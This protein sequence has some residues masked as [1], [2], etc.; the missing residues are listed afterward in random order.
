MDLTLLTLIKSLISMFLLMSLGFLLAKLKSEFSAFSGPMAELLMTIFLPATIIQSLLGER[1]ESFLRDATIVFFIG[2]ILYVVL[3][4]LSLFFA[5]VCKIRPY[6]RGTWALCATFPNNGFMGYPII[7]AM[8]GQEALALAAV[9]GVSFS[10]IFYTWG[11]HIISTDKKDSQTEKVSLK[12]A[13]IT[14]TN[15]ATLVGILCFVFG[16]QIPEV[17]LT[18]ISLCANVST[19]LSM[20][21]IGIKLAE[22]KKLKSAINMDVITASL[23]KLIIFPAIAVLVLSRITLPNSVIMPMIVLTVAMPT[24]AVVSVITEKY[25]INCDLA[26]EVTFFTGMCCIVTVPLIALML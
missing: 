8:L 18:P 3:G 25:S 26:A 13:L 9:M 6:R 11:A 10:A 15:I 1:E 17:L 12:E 21:I 2:I 4:A 14:P 24:A 16:I 23:F 19:P 7:L 5:R 20:M 22:I